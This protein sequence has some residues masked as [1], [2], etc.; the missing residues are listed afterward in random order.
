M[1][2]LDLISQKVKIH[3]MRE[4]VPNLMTVIQKIELKGN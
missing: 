1:I 4:T 2:V 3:M